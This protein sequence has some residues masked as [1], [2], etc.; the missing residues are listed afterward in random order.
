[1]DRLEC[2]NCGHAISDDGPCPNCGSMERMILYDLLAR[3]EIR[4]NISF[5]FRSR[6]AIWNYYP[7]AIKFNL[8]AIETTTDEYLRKA[9]CLQIINSTAMLVEGVITDSMEED[10]ES[11]LYIPETREEVRKKLDG[12]NFSNWRK[13]KELIIDYLGWNLE[14][15]EGFEI[16]DILFS[17][18]D[19]TGHGR[20]YRL[21][22]A[23]TMQDKVLRRSESIVIENERY[24]DAYRKLHERGWVPPINDY[25]TIQEEVFLW[26]AVASGFYEIGVIFLHSFFKNIRLKSG[27]TF[28]YEFENALKR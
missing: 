8:K 20:S 22:D 23:R 17:L 13:K 28:R 3:P 6:I 2:A 10:L 26:P 5:S 27:V 21:T 19:N 18:R 4:D 15:L 7:A 16:M 12:L 11:V 14:Q 9:L 1:M 24:A 25:A